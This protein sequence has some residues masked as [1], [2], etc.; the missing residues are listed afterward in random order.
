MRFSPDSVAIY[1]PEDEL[2]HP[3]LIVN[4]NIAD[5]PKGIYMLKI[6]PELMNS[7]MHSK[8]NLLVQTEF[9]RQSNSSQGATSNGK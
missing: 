6:M 3:E 1:V 2:N 8:Y 5:A 9:Q 4:L 7:G